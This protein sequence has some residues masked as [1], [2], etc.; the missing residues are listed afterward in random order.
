MADGAGDDHDSDPPI[1]NFFDGIGSIDQL[2]QTLPE[3]ARD[4]K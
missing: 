2:A 4:N 3:R 1:F